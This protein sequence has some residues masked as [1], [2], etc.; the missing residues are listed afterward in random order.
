M[1]FLFRDL[2]SVGTLSQTAAAWSNAPD[3]ICGVWE[4]I[5]LKIV[6]MSVFSHIFRIGKDL[7]IVSHADGD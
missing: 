2:A 5:L 7:I 3:E 4:I 1:F 6:L